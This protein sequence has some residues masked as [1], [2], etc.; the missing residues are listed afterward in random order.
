MIKQSKC[1]I[2]RRAS[3]K[4]FLKGDRCFSAKCAI[5][6]RPYAP[7]QKPKR[8]RG[9]VS[10]Y[11]KELREKQKIKK[12]YNL[13]EQ[14]F[15]NYVK[16]LLDTRT[17]LVEDVPSAL[18]KNIET[19]LDNIVFRL[20]FARS[21]G[22]ARQMVTHGHFLV[23][24]KRT[25]IPSRQIK[26]NDKIS[27]RKGSKERA[28]FKNIEE[29]MKKTQLP[30]WLSM[31]KKTLEAEIKRYPKIED[32]QLLGELSAVFEHYSR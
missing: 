10:E 3:E 27:I 13:T 5:V 25:N 18:I 6:K 2:C 8:R 16:D 32:V 26:I 20:G 4:L 22:E 14:E 21:R 29:K 1:K 19:R 11:G 12:S 30:A 23:N 24:Q 31:D 9:G 17:K 28:I 15:R 7:G